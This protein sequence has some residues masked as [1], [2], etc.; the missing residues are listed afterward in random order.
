MVSKISLPGGRT[1]P[2][3]A[4]NCE[5]TARY[6]PPP[7]LTDLWQSISVAGNKNRSFRHEF[8]GEAGLSQKGKRMR[9]TRAAWI[10]FAALLTI[11]T[12]APAAAEPMIRMGYAQ[13][14]GHLAP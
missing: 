4:Q 11:G 5:S 8:S 2:L 10:I 9:T 7:R 6:D 1:R 13:L 3:I 12:A 14:P